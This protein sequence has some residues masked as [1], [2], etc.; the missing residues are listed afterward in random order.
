MKDTQDIIAE[1]PDAFLWED[2][3][4][5]D[6]TLEDDIKSFLEILID[7]KCIKCDNG[8]IAG[9]ERMCQSIDDNIRGIEITCKSCGQKWFIHKRFPKF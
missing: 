9:N 8:V 1:I 6:V 5:I 3:E 7:Y 2:K 4:T